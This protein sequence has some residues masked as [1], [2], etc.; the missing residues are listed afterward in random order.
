MQSEDC[1]ATS[2]LLSHW[3]LS[4]AQNGKDRSLRSAQALRSAKAPTRKYIIYHWLTTPSRFEQSSHSLCRTR[5]SFCTDCLFEDN[6]HH[7][8]L[9][10]LLLRLP[11]FNVS[12]KSRLP[13]LIQTFSSLLPSTSRSIL[14]ALQRSS[15]VMPPTSRLM[16]RG[17]PLKLLAGFNNIH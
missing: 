7:G 8:K 1:G 16:A 11:G 10:P 2:L 12:P 14:L 3:R 5:Q 13:R 17:T 4:I 9:L 15:Q 6:N